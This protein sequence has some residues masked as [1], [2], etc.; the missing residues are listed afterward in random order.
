MLDDQLLVYDTQTDQIHLLNSTTAKVLELVEEGIGSDEVVKRLDEI[1]GG[2]QG[3]DLLSLALGELRSAGLLETK[4][5]EVPKIHETTRRQMVQRIAAA[6]AVI[7]VPAIITLAPQSAAAQGSQLANGS[8]CTASGQCASGCC[9]SNSA[10]A[11]T[12]HL[13]S[14]TPGCGNCVP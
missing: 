12:N 5:V 1:N 2:S 6:G 10:G 13:C 7:L 8:A 11:C 4:N 9:A 14:P 3:A